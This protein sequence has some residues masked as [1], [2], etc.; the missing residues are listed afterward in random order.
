MVI[1]FEL[2]QG[3]AFDLIQNITYLLLEILLLP[4]YTVHLTGRN[5][6]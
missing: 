2:R 6:A 4:V 3:A 5:S 1:V